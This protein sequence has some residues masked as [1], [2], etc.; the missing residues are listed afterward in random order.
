MTAIRQ[1]WTSGGSLL[2]AAAMGFQALAQNLPLLESV[3]PVSE[4][5]TPTPVTIVP[6]EKDP[7]R[8]VLPGVETY[9]EPSR[10]GAMT[11]WRNHCHDKLWGYPG[12]FIDAPLGASVRAHVSVQVVAGQAARMALYQYDFVPMT[13]QLKP[14]GRAGLAQIAEW[15]LCIP[16]PVF[17]EPT[18]GR[19]DL[20]EARRQSV[21][22]EL[23]A[24]G[25]RVPGERIVIG[26]PS[27]LG[28][29]GA[30]SLI[31][32]RNRL[33][34]TLSRGA[35]AGGGAA[36]VGAAGAGGG[37]AGAMGRGY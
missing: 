1:G 26:Y 18:P 8:A 25:Y 27:P 23:A 19:P 34:Q 10:T 11:R 36:G 15:T 21:W 5:P 29:G 16:A 13:A 4:L 24:G 31:L 30:E 32:D 9:C 22:R 7:P 6:L 2:L 20:D 12:E 37:A 14:R 33:A 17:V 3:N 28:L 35:G